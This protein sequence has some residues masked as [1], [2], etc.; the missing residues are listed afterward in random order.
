MRVIASL[1]E[2][3]DQFVDDDLEQ[4]IE[5][6]E[7]I[8]SNVQPEG[9]IIFVKIYKT[10]NILVRSMASNFSL[11]EAGLVHV[12]DQVNS[13]TEQLIMRVG[14]LE[15]EERNLQTKLEQLQYKEEGLEKQLNNQRS[16][17]RQQQANLHDLQSSLNQKQ[18]DYE[19]EERHRRTVR[20]HM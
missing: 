4:E 5:L 17:L 18:R 14:Q 12:Q 8:K 20:G 2:S 16:A 9:T 1:G 19:A 13:D 11:A 10:W 6:L 15:N 3:S 7:G